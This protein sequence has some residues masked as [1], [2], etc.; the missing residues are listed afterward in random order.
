V[1]FLNEGL[2]RKTDSRQ[3]REGRKREGGPAG[4]LE[5]AC[6]TVRRDAR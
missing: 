2:V 4:K 5:A 6:I 3:A 1:G